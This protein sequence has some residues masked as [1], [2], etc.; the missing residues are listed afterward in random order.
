ME[1]SMSII[2]FN[3]VQQLLKVRNGVATGYGSS[4]A[5]SIEVM[6]IFASRFSTVKLINIK[7]LN[8]SL[9]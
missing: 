9:Q 1:K 6:L 8:L 5:P 7:S 4:Y 2:D 3:F